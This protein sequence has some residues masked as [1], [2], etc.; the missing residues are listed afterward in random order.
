MHVLITIPAHNEEKTIG[1]VIGNIK[2]VMAK[3]KHKYDV[4]VVDDGSTDK[5]GPVARKAGAFVVSHPYNYGLAETF[6]TEMKQVL[7]KKPDVIVHID[8]DGQYQPDEIPKLMKPIEEGKADLVLG[9]RFMGKI[10]KMPVIKRWGNKAFSRAISKVT[11]V[12]ITDGQTGFRAFTG[13][14]AEKVKIISTHTYTQE[15]VIKAIKEKFRVIE[16]PIYF[17]KRKA[18]KSK[19]ISNPFGYALRAWVNIFR[20]YRDFEP[21][22][23]F[24]TIAGIFI[25]LGVL[26]GLYL[27]YLFIVQGYIGHLPATILSMLLMVSGLQILIFGFLADMKK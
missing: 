1:D 24:G 15:M 7:L 14:V 27:F 2:K 5:T 8:A 10:E 18:G 11:G 25:F 12:K 3:S 9:S 26:I 23:F 13:E 22:K 6:R 19:L 20:I 4:M 21:L 17:A 16:V